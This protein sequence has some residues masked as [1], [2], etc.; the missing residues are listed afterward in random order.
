MKNKSIVEDCDRLIQS[1][2]CLSKCT[3]NGCNKQA[4]CG[5]H[6]MERGRMYY[7]HMLENIVPLCIPHHTGTTLSPHGQKGNYD[8]HMKIYA[9]E[10][11]VWK[12]EMKGVEITLAKMNR[13]RS[14]PGREELTKTHRFLQ[15]FLKRG[16]PFDWV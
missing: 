13:K 7:R 5:H 11:K 4:Q 3:I 6:N 10:W 1:I 8:V 16:E 12:D 14:V 15:E 2:A 9:P